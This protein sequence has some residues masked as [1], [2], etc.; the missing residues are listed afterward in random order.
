MQLNSDITEDNTCVYFHVN[1]IS[2]EI[3]YVGI[4][5]IDRPNSKRRSNWWHNVVNK[6][7]YDIIIIHENLSWEEACSLE[8]KYIAQIGR[9][10]KG[11]G[12]LVNMTDGGEGHTGPLKEET[13]IKMS[14]SRMGYKPTAESIKKLSESNKKFHLN[15]PNFQSGKNAFWYNKTM[16]E[17][18]R[19]KMS[20]AHSGHLGYNR[21]SVSQFDKQGNFINKFTSI[22]E[23]HILTQIHLGLIS[24]VCNTKYSAG[25]FLWKT[26]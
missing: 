17:S 9:A 18:T 21:L 11:L 25:G 2:Q 23:A 7:G 12:T 4:G 22:T 1:F 20:K 3:F 26:E 16:D 8:I 14:K 13:K 19:S 5:N 6:Y 15:N 24:R 10:D